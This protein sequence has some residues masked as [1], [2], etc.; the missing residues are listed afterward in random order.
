MKHPFP[1]SRHQEGMALISVL[2][3]LFLLT[4]LVVAFMARTTSARV[5]AVNYHATATTR[6]LADTAV[7]L[8]Q[9]QINEATTLGMG[10]D[11]TAPTDTWGSQ[12]GAIRVFNNTGTLAYV[13]RLYSAA[14]GTASTERKIDVTGSASSAAANSAAVTAMFDDLPSATNWYQYGAQWCDLNAF[15]KDSQG[16]Y[17]FPILDLRDPGADPTAD[18]TGLTAT[19]WQPSSGVPPLQGFSVYP[20]GA[21]SPG[22]TAYTVGSITNPA[23]MPVRWL[24]VL[25]DGAIISPDS[26]QNP[27][28][29]LTFQGAVDSLGAADPPTVANPIVGRIAF[30]TDDDSCKININTAAG[31]DVLRQSSS[32]GNYGNNAVYTH[33]WP[34]QS[35][36]WATP[37]FSANDE[38]NMAIFQPA[39]G[40]VQRYPGVPGTV[41]LNSTLSIL[42]GLTTPLSY[43]DFYSLTP[44]Y[45]GSGGSNA[46]GTI[47]A[48]NPDP[49]GGAAENT[50]PLAAARLY[51]SVGEMLFNVQ[52]QESK[53]VTDG[54]PVAG[55]NQES[56]AA[57]AVER[58]NFFLTAHSSSSELNLW[59]EPRVSMWPYSTTYQ[60]PE[61]NLLAFDAKIARTTAGAEPFYFQRTDP[62]STTTDANIPGNIKLLDYLDSLTSAPVIPGF[63]RNFTADKYPNTASPPAMRQILSE[64]FDYVRT[65]NMI[66]PILLAQ[67]PNQSISE[68]YG[69]NWG[70]PTASIVVNGFATQM[71]YNNNGSGSGGNNYTYR[72]GGG[73]MQVVPSAN[74]NSGLNGWGTQ[75]IGAFPIPV[76]VSIDF[77]AVGLGQQLDGT[78]QTTPGTP[79]SYQIVGKTNNSVPGTI[80]APQYGDPAVAHDTAGNPPARIPGD[81]CNPA[82]GGGGG[83]QG[84]DCTTAMQAFVYVAFVNPGM[85]TSTM[86]PVFC[87]SITGLNSLSVQGYATFNISKSNSTKLPPYWSTLPQPAPPANGSNGEDANIPTL[88]NGFSYGQQTAIPLHFPG[89][90]SNGTAVGNTNLSDEEMM[91]VDN[92]DGAGFDNGYV[93]NY[94]W[95]YISLYG[96][97]GNNNYGSN[98]ALLSPGQNVWSINQAV[99][100]QGSVQAPNAARAFPFYSQIFCL[101]GQVPS[102]VPLSQNNVGNNWTDLQGNPNPSNKFSFLG[103]NNNLIT[104]KTYSYSHDG[105][106]LSKSASGNLISSYQFT[107]PSVA[108]PNGVPLLVLPT[109]S[110]TESQVIGTTGNAGNYG[111]GV[112]RW[113]YAVDGGDDGNNF[114]QIHFSPNDVVQSVVLSPAWSDVRDL[115][116]HNVTNQAHGPFAGHPL[117]GVNTQA[118]DLWV[119]GEYPFVGNES[120]TNWGRLVTQTVGSTTDS[121]SPNVVTT[122]AGQGPQRLTTNY[123]TVPPR[124]NGN[125]ASA[126]TTGSPVA[127][128]GAYTYSSVSPQNSGLPG[129][130]DNGVAFQPDGPWVNMADEGALAQRP[131]GADPAAVGYFSTG[132][133]AQKTSISSIF[134]PNR[135]IPSP[136]MFGSLPTGV[137][138]VQP[139]PWQTLLFRPGP[140]AGGWGISGK[141][142]YGEKDQP[143]GG[144]PADHLLL[145]LFWMP[146]VEPYPI[147]QQ[148]QT[149]GKINLN[150]EIQPFSYITRDTALRALFSSEEIAL[151]PDALAAAYKNT[152]YYV[153]AASTATIPPVRTIGNVNIQ[154][155]TGGYDQYGNSRLPIDPNQ[156]LGLNPVLGQDPHKPISGTVAA[157]QTAQ[158]GSTAWY[159]YVTSSTRF[160]KSA[161]EICEMFL[162]P[163]GYDWK[164]FTGYGGL[165]SHSWYQIPNGDFA[166]VG[167]NTREKPYADLYPR[168]TTKSNTYTVYYTVQA[169]RNAEPRATYPSS[170][171]PGQQIWDETKGAIMGEYRGSTTL[172]RYIDPN[173]T[174]PDFLGSPGSIS[175]EPY[176]KWRI[177]ETRQF[178]P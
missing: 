101:P 52:R 147:S 82:A 71:D 161:S 166:L 42:A 128:S 177:L 78:V 67:T 175:L 59:G 130:W 79:P 54:T 5:A 95:G 126:G 103:S 145:D 18:P 9:A 45:G 159:D 157:T 4:I 17:H 119:E 92:T 83:G 111:P 1:R 61:D 172:E 162:V 27:S 134:S 8:V 178:A 143:L 98:P 163:Q 127:G 96:E 16:R 123:P 56:E 112:N 133:T 73:G 33:W 41:G 86:Q 110:N 114:F 22:G 47:S 169:L 117:Y 12:P 153:G 115:C 144:D 38:A 109:Y 176:Y 90:V 81:T 32:S 152:G 55:E 65:I 57:A 62:T 75:G 11:G 36:F 46:L 50:I 137:S 3:V 29:T 37:V 99:P 53:L 141:Y 70:L 26:P 30:W 116:M 34:S 84:G 139:H 132:N 97:T 118:H 135:E 40:E 60:T 105:Q 100:V 43:D 69:Q 142:H 108:L 85:I 168:L 131:D 165:N 150:Y 107:F 146:Q 19:L 138:S 77:A 91:I 121:Y 28:N 113:T 106:L 155:A 148:F 15:A 13:Y 171:T 154:G 51:T 66:D 120:P 14:P 35:I 49:I 173:Q 80:P 136:V 68:T 102:S 93:G 125:S 58:S 39:Q 170:M 156:T 87:Y 89:N 21:S 94:V 10:T 151:M 48:T 23:P 88:V 31:D 76:E 158:T 24:Y 167:D 74:G 160:F 6:V 122:P 129:D 44:R 63:G 20:S 25:K 72:A 2:A 149:E 174:L 64:M 140:G 7:N 164:E 124:L 104:L